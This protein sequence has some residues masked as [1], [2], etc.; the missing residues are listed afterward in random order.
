M[1]TQFERTGNP[2]PGL[3]PFDTEEY[4]LFFGRDGQSDE[5]LLRLARTRF[6]AVVGTSGSGKSSLIRAGLIPALYGGLMA[7]TGSAWR[8]AVFRPGSDPIGNLARALSADDVLGSPDI[9]DATEAAIVETT[10]RRSTL[11]LV[12]AVRQRR[13]PAYENVLIVVDQFEELFRFRSTR[14]DGGSHDEAAAFVKLLLEAPAQRDVNI[15][16]VVTMRSDFLG[17]CAQFWGLPEAINAGQ[18]LIPRMTRDERRSAITGPASVGGGEI[19]PPLV[20]RLL[21][22]AGDNPDQ[23]PILQHALMRTWDYW[24]VH[25]RNGDPVGLEDYEAVGAMTEA[26]SRHAEE[27]FAELPDERSR[28]VAALM[29]KALTERG[30]DN[31][32]TRRPT[33]LSEICA[34][35]EASEDEVKQVVEVFRREGRSFL[36]PPA[37]TPLAPETVIDISHESLIRNW[38]RLKDWVRDE[39]EAARIYRRLAVAAEGHRAGEVGLL[40][41]VTLQWVLK[42]KESYKPN[43]AWG[44]RYHPGYDE[45]L[46]Y[47]EESRAARASE[48]AERERQRQELLD[49]ERREREQAEAFAAS[50]ARGA[51]RLRRF[52]V[53][54][55]AISLFALLAAFA[56]AFAFARARSNLKLAEQNEARVEKLAY[57]LKSSFDAERSAKEDAQQQ[58][59]DAEAARLKAEGEEKKALEE[60]K[61]AQSEKKRAE[62]EKKR[63]ESEKRRADD[64][65]RR[66]EQQAAW[67]LAAKRLAESTVTALQANGKFR[68]ATILA[69]RGQYPQATA[70]YEETI[71]GLRQYAGDTEGVA[72]A[73]VQ[74]G[75]THFDAMPDATLGPA[76]YDLAG[77]AVKSYD[78]AVEN[79][80]EAGAHAK[81]ADTLLSVGATLLKVSNEVPVGRP[82][83]LAS[84]ELPSFSAFPLPVGGDNG[85]FDEAEAKV[86]LKN[87]A[88]AR[89]KQA[90]LLYR[91]GGD[92]NGMMRA[93]YRIGNFYLR[94][95]LPA[96]QDKTPTLDIAQCSG[97]E[98][99]YIPNRQKALCY[100]KELERLSLARGKK[101]VDIQRL[102]VLLGG[103]NVGLGDREAAEGYFK[104]ALDASTQPSPGLMRAGRS[105][106]DAWLDAAEV[107][108]AAGLYDAA[109]NLYER[110]FN[111]YKREGDFAGQAQTYFRRGSIIQKVN[112]DEPGA[113]S[114]VLEMFRQAI[115]AYNQNLKAGNSYAWRDEFFAIGSFAEDNYDDALALDAYKSALELGR[116]SHDELTQARAWN[117]IASVQSQRDAAAARQSDMNAFILYSKLR[118]EALANSPPLQ[119]QAD[120]YLK[121]LE[122]ISSVVLSLDR[123]IK[124]S[125]GVMNLGSPCAFPVIAYAQPS[126]TEGNTVIFS[127][128]AV[129]PQA[130][131]VSYEWSLNSS[132]ATI[133]ERTLKPYPAIRVST[134]G[135]GTGDL[136]AT[137][138]VSAGTGEQS[139]KQTA[140][141]TTRLVAKPPIPTH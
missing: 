62:D 1:S 118:D 127:A 105:A 7:Q 107:A 43:R 6:L 47:L 92:E 101:D 98:Q 113:I 119:T 18:Y 41:D 79:Y 10:L 88:L 129:Y 64:E 97:V 84:E 96:W 67:A 135:V 137:L 77:R 14:A 25:R 83:S 106:S 42:W 39:A 128:Y 44:V 122:R 29:F 2:F 78:E 115:A 120:E 126:A 139:C 17:D 110:A 20:N 81:A 94:D 71:K 85:G 140:H 45:A 100:L 87:Q 51:R 33:R 5:L 104:R 24:T 54:L 89:Y 82:V 53:A 69:E 50:Q 57:D 16:V 141:A 123:E 40:D 112:K 132:A 35:V 116:R 21:N 11:G 66:A 22:D 38:Q 133:V 131:D 109:L 9:D 76:N 4:N 52:T 68:D 59:S 99:E 32:E 65:A 75:Q 55:I 70:M 138:V 34:V 46:G 95:E 23:L 13:L 12:D 117:G 56:S 30:A 49:R 63:A 91:K 37:G 58:R 86:R 72:D 111:E 114:S 124:V 15:Y 103:I 102:L 93:A 26:L 134:N 3:R 74:L 90:F 61:R 60:Q 121:E 136:V 36:M 108:E 27:A 31:R 8:I 48:A 19:S 80:E 125:G 130:L 73:Y 28:T